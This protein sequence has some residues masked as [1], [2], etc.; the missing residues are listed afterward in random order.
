MITMD[1]ISIFLESHWVASFLLA[2]SFF[3]L[4]KW[5]LNL[6]NE[7][8]KDEIRRWL[9]GKVDEHT[10]AFH[11][12]RLFDGV[13]GRKHLSWRCFFR[14]G[15]CSL[16]AVVLAWSI[17]GGFTDFSFRVQQ[18]STLL[19]VLGLGVLINVFADYLSL[20]ETR[21][22]LNILRK[23]RI[24]IVQ[25]T[26]LLLDF[27]LSALIILSVIWLYLQTPF[28]DDEVYKISE[29]IGLFSLY[30]VFFYSTFLTSL[31]SWVFVSSTWI[32]RAFNQGR[33]YRLLDVEERP[34]LMLAVVS[35]LLVFLF[36]LP[37]SS[38]L[39]KQEGSLS[40]ADR[41][42]CSVFKDE[43]CWK[44]SGL[45]EDEETE[46]QL[47]A[48]YCRGGNYQECV[49]R[50]SSLTMSD[51]G[52][53]SVYLQAACDGGES[54]SC[55]NLGFM[56][57]YG[58]GV[59]QDTTRA[60]DILTLTCGA[61]HGDACAIIGRIYRD[62][63]EV[64]KSNE[65]AYTYFVKGCDFE[66]ARSCSELALIIGNASQE[67]VDQTIA[68]ELYEKACNLRDT[69]GCHNLGVRYI[70]GN[71]IERSIDQAFSKFRLACKEGWSASCMNL[72]TFH[73]QLGDLEASSESYRDACDLDYAEG[74]FQLALN[75]G[76]GRGVD[77]DID[78]SKTLMSKAC[79]DGYAEACD[80]SEKYEK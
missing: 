1:Q 39:Q 30:T 72:G 11:F 34:D 70:E 48:D 8:R 69:L 7:E 53:I 67:P 51:V 80:L 22:L 62:G 74:C 50:A 25:L 77:Q 16:V 46:F 37:I 73:K 40:I 65:K 49:S 29:I 18:E 3:G 43:I 13:F 71:G 28:N 54:E 47:I 78:F 4:T 33:L 19:N 15:I 9:S 27:I 42:L 24:F 36:S 35:S 31:W 14:S 5:S 79:E 41:A 12:I 6:L 64:T 76:L 10:W 56:Y 26:M 59:Q 58:Y 32:F 21:W 20:L 60:L 44:L 17:L 2:T 75:Y 23:P 61:K 55:N 66:D 63:F 52:R 38:I 68:V 57:A 45:T